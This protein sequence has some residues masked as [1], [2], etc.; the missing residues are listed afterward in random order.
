MWPTGPLAVA[1][2]MFL[3][4]KRMEVKNQNT[5]TIALA[6]SSAPGEGGVHA[7]LGVQAFLTEY[8]RV[9]VRQVV[10]LLV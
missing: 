9:L 8:S 6:D 4:A 7:V 2:K 3:E 10:V 1:A 5:C